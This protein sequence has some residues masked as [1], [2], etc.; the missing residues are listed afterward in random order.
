MGRPNRVYPNLL[1]LFD[2]LHTRKAKMYCGTEITA[3]HLVKE[4]AEYFISI[5]SWAFCCSKFKAKKKHTELELDIPI[6]T[7]TAAVKYLD[8]CAWHDWVDKEIKDNNSDMIETISLL[9]KLFPNKKKVY[10]Y[11]FKSIVAAFCHGTFVRYDDDGNVEEPTEHAIKDRKYYNSKNLHFEDIEM[12]DNVNKLYEAYH[13][14]HK[15]TETTPEERKEAYGKYADAR[16]KFVYENHD[17][18]NSFIKIGESVV[19]CPYIYSRPTIE[20][21]S[22]EHVG[23]IYMVVT[24]DTVYFEAERHY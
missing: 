1:H 19:V 17:K 24:E 7:D 3:L 20:G 2:K 21:Y 10:F 4:T 13:E 15:N 16:D 23:E 6:L 5:D 12:P 14:T 9:D 22:Y 18:T 11:E 8:T